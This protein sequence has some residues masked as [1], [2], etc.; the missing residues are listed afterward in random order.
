MKQQCNLA[1]VKQGIR[2]NGIALAKVRHLVVFNDNRISGNLNKINE[3][4]ADIAD[5]ADIA[6]TKVLRTC[7]ELEQNGMEKNGRYLIDPDGPMI[8]QDPIEVYCDFENG[9]TEVLHDMHQ[10]MIEVEECDADPGCAVYNLT[11]DVPKEQIEALIQLS[12]SCTQ[13][14]T[15]HDYLID[16]NES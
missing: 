13:V 4:K 10:Q 3:N 2:Q 1:A 14:I 11:Y 5:V 8:G 7:Y 6:N 16:P 15:L 12:D 9:L